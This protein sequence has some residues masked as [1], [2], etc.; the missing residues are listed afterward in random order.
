MG[1]TDHSGC[2]GRRDGY[3]FSK[4]N[5]FQLHNK[6][7]WPTPFSPPSCLFSSTPPKLL[8]ISNKNQS[9][10]FCYLNSAKPHL[11]DLFPFQGIFLLKD[12]CQR[13]SVSEAGHYFILI[14]STT[15]FSI[16][17]DFILLSSRSIQ[18]KEK[19]WTYLHLKT[20]KFII[21]EEAL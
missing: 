11:W 18:E 19:H 9:R 7:I 14:L 4:A 2:L 10:C 12:N 16:S 13:I 6:T 1:V 21:K 17:L 20:S 5:H 8:L 3:F 15:W